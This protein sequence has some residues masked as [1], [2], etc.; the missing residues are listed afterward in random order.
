MAAYDATSKTP[1]GPAPARDFIRQ[2]IDEDNRTG[3]WGGRVH[4]RFPPEPNGYLH[5]GHA[6][7]ICLNFGLAREFGGQCNLRFDDTNPAKEEVEY[8][9]AIQDDVH[10]LGFDWEDRRF[11]ASNYFDQLYALPK[12]SSA[13]G[14]PTWTTSPRKPSG[15]TA[16]P[17]TEPGTDSPLAQPLARGESRPLPPDAGRGIPGRGQ[18]A[19]GQDRHE[20]PQLSSCA[21]RCLYRIKHV[22][23]HPH[24]RHLVHLSD[25]RLHPLHFRRPGRGDPF[26]VLPGIR[27]QPPPLRLGPRPPARALPSAADRV[28]PPEPVLYG[29]E[30]AQAHPARHG[31]GRLRLGRSAAADLKRHP[32][33]RLHARG[34]PRLLRPHRHLHLRQHGGHGPAGT[35]PARGPEPPG[36]AGHGRAPSAEGGHRDLS[37]GAD[38]E[39]DFP[40]TPRT[41]RSARAKC[42]FPARS[43]SNATISGKSSRRSGSARPPEPK[44]GCATPIT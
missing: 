27:K 43:T 44:C 14:S 38:R 35:L 1:A 10:W 18:G 37:R 31:K 25:V 16:A 26:P 22:T 40:T 39:I 3:K 2:I 4:T 36:Q 15:P 19:A 32:P 33:T 30:Q 8:V 28:R 21:I 13:R 29:V 41:P 23:H 5:I 7:S 20:K 11:Y 34:H 42:R 9:D 24:R 6:K 12:S 17:L